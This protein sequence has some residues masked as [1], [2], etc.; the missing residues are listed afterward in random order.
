MR[1]LAAAP[2]QSVPMLAELLQPAPE[3]TRERIARL[4]TDLVA[5]DFPVRHRADQELRKLGTAAE[6][7]LREALRGT[8][9]RRG[10]AEKAEE[11]HLG[12]EDVRALRAVEALAGADTAEARRAL[13]AVAR[14]KP[15]SR[16]TR[17]ARAALARLDGRPAGAP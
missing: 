2:R 17:R 14:R 10:L 6:P 13:E 5:R 15:E 7:T 4:I 3:A 8:P 12:P 11:S 1:A 9:P 16:L